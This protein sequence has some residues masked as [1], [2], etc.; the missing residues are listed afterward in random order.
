M[1]QQTIARYRDRPAAGAV[2]A[3]QLMK[4]A[5]QNVAVFGVGAGGVA[6][7]AP[8]ARALGADLDVARRPAA[9]AAGST[10]SAVGSC[11]CAR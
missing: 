4:Y 2:L 10:G 7:A 5:G 6:V 8:I 11:C 3:E 9:D 1:M